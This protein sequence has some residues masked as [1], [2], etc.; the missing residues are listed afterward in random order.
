LSGPVAHAQFAALDGEASKL[1]RY[2]LKYMSTAEGMI[3]MA[4][5][6]KQIGS[7]LPKVPSL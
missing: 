6:L 3:M 4:P 2:H 1:I 7:F 5:T